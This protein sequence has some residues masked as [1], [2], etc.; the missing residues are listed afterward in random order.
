MGHTCCH[1]QY[2]IPIPLGRMYITWSSLTNLVDA[3]NSI[4][5]RGGEARE[6][7]RAVDQHEMETIRRTPIAQWGYGASKLIETSEKI[8]KVSQVLPWRYR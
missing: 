4:T 7:W 8:V 6:S 1:I 3:L 5:L 2:P